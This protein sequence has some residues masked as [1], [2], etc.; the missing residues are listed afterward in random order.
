MQPDKHELKDA[1][2]SY[3]EE[4]KKELKIASDYVVEIKRI[5]DNHKKMGLN[6]KE[7]VYIPSLKNEDT[8]IAEATKQ[9]S[10]M[11]FRT[12]RKR[13]RKA[14][15]GFINRSVCREKK[16][17]QMKQNKDKRHPSDIDCQARAKEFAKFQEEQILKRIQERKMR[18]KEEENHEP[19]VSV[20]V[21]HDDFNSPLS[22]ANLQAIRLSGIKLPFN[23][24]KVRFLDENENIVD[25]IT[26]FN[27]EAELLVYHS[28][29]CVMKFSHNNLSLIEDDIFQATAQKI[30]TLFLDALSVLLYIAHA[31][32][33]FSSATSNEKEAI[34]KKT[35]NSQSPSSKELS[36]KSI[37]IRLDF[38][39]RSSG[40]SEQSE[41][42]RTL[43]KTI[44]V[45]GHW[46]NQ[47]YI[48]ETKLIWINPFWKGK[49][50]SDT[51][52]CQ[53]VYRVVYEGKTQ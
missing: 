20:E 28:S 26:L 3:S 11:V 51:Q 23:H 46:R 12:P 6:K 43:S 25:E 19:L 7:E 16:K 52:K 39:N 15:N 30:Q 48:N 38:Q 1:K 33:G 24:S 4:F 34:I 29:E 53:P 14:L 5:L 40:V 47:R 49:S 22:R 37:T 17:K 36:T 50:I 18:E 8:L 35:S 41:T 2:L 21:F 45:R 27:K 42:Y 31:N 10:L 13:L 32:Q 44:F 9:L